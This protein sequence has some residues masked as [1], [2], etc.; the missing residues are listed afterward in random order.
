MRLPEGLG[1]RASLT[2]ALA[3]LIAVTALALVACGGSGTSTPGSPS[4]AGS[5][6]TVVDWSPSPSEDATPYPTPTVVGTIAFVRVFDGDLFGGDIYTVRTDGTELTP[7][8]AHPQ[9]DELGGA[10]SPD[11]RTVVYVRSDTAATLEGEAYKLW[12]MKPDGSAQRR[13]ARGIA[14]VSPSWSPDGDRFVFS[15]W[16]G[17]EDET[18]ELTTAN[19]YGSDL[20]KVARGPEYLYPT[21]G[22]DGRIYFLPVGKMDVYSVNPD[23]SGLT[24]VTKLGDVGGYGLSRD[25]KEL[26]V[27]QMYP[28][29]R[30][31]VLPASGRGTPRVIV[32]PVPDSLTG[33]VV[34]LSWS[35]DGKAVAFSNDS[36]DAPAGSDL[37]IVNADGTGLSVV[38]D[39]GPVWEVDWLRQ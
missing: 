32:K 35:P 23:G 11:G 13:L 6:S 17:W 10:W 38:P 4:A 31:V 16:Y 1:P 28:R 24:R 37:F 29:D 26:A 36:Y 19:A 12:T 9:R 34:S 5:P 14:G 18:Y 3:S 22:A 33:K 30:I 21:W 2:L 39:T 8:A 25:G 7:V 27:F 20:K 15:R